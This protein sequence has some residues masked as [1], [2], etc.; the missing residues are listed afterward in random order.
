MPQSTASN[1]RP[2]ADRVEAA[3]DEAIAACDGH[4]RAALRALIVAN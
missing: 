1:P 4:V 2:D 3:A